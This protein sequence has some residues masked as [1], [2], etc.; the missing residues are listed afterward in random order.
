[1]KFHQYLNALNNLA[2]SD[3]ELD[4]MDVIFATDDE[5]NDFNDVVFTPIVGERKDGEF[6]ASSKKPNAICIN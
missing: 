1:M 4:D 2:S 3:G 5:G 6:N